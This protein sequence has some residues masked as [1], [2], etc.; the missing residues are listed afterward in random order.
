MAPASSPPQLN[1]VTA[2]F[3]EALGTRVG[4]IN[5]ALYQLNYSGSKDNAR[6]DNWGYIAI[7]GF[8]NADGIGTLDANKL[9][10]GLQRLRTEK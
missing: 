6:G 2:L 1:G 10:E 4:Q 3:V 8:D 5:P 7:P 9:L